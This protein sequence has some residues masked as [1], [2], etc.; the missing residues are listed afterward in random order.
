MTQHKPKLHLSHQALLDDIDSVDLPHGQAALWWL[1]QHSFILKLGRRVLY[2]DPF[3]TPMPERLLPPL[4]DP[5]LIRHADF[6]LGSHDHADHIDRPIWPLL[7][8]ASPQARFILPDLLKD[9]ITADTGIPP[10]RFIGLDDL[11]TYRADDLCITGIP[12]AHEFPAADPLTGRF[13]CIGFVI[14]GH[15]C[16][17][18][19]PG[20]TCP[21]E[22][23]RDRIRRWRYDLMMLP[24]NGRDAARFAAGI[25]GNFTF[26]EAADLAGPL[27]PGLVIPTHYDMFASNPGDPIAFRDYMAVKYPAVPTLL[28]DYGRRI[29]ITHKPPPL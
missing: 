22:G 12:S 7:A 19:H 27:R 5:R 9:S 15:G 16:T 23:L 2:I 3:F 4:L 20:D 10:D 11:T 14:Q 17:I 28:P 1:G 6:I 18:Y 21:Y 25:L 8:A 29:L 13:P 24:I 26:Q